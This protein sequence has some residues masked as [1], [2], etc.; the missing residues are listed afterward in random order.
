M[1]DLGL[2]LVACLTAGEV[3][4]DGLENM[5]FGGGVGML[6]ELV[7]EKFGSK[8]GAAGFHFL[9]LPLSTLPASGEFVLPTAVLGIV[10]SS[11]LSL[12]L[13][14]SKRGDFL[15]MPLSCLSSLIL[16]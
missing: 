8:E 11:S 2:V 16:S 9:V 7:N 3:L 12:S 5:L 1:N 4:Y 6:G 10:H 15:S 13:E 14:N